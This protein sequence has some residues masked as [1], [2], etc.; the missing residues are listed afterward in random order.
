MGV[1]CNPSF[2]FR[3]E[4]RNAVEKE[5]RGKNCVI[6]AVAGLAIAGISGPTA[7]AQAV[8]DTQKTNYLPNS[9]IPGPDVV[10]LTDTFERSDSQAE[11]ICAGFYIFDENEQLEECCGCPISE[12]GLLTVQSASGLNGPAAATTTTGDL[13][14]NPFFDKAGGPVPGTA[15]RFANVKIVSFNINPPNPQLGVVDPLICD[16]TAGV[17]PQGQYP[18]PQLVGHGTFNPLS[19]T[20]SIRAWATHFQNQANITESEFRDAPLTQSD[21]DNYARWCAAIQQAGSGRGVCSCGN[22]TGI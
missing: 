19:L 18:F 16:T 12:D 3:E 22:D 11:I 14:S 7:W 2:E 4:H 9:Q 1:I 15:L 21:A 5:S 20:P 6:A 10:N 13:V 17:W 8:S